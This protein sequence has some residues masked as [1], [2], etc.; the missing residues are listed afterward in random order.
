VLQVLQ[1]LQNR[2]W[3]HWQHGGEAVKGYRQQEDPT[4]SIVLIGSISHLADVGLSAYIED[5]IEAERKIKASLSRDVKVGHL[6][7]R[8]GFF[9]TQKLYTSSILRYIY[10][11]LFFGS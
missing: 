9:S 5:M 10:A 11:I 8:Y 4:C 2:K 6:L 3:Q 7:S 1:D